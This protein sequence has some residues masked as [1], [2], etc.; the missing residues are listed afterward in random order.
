MQLH[1]RIEKTNVRGAPGVK[2]AK[3][4]QR[5]NVQDKNEKSDSKRTKDSP[6]AEGSIGRIG[7]F[8]FGSPPFGENPAGKA[9]GGRFLAT[10]I[11]LGA[12][13]Q[14]A[15]QLVIKVVH[16]NCRMSWP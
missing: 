15:F 11:T 2:P 12:R 6:S 9:K 1:G 4:F 16:G 3:R 14:E 10:A 8:A 13:P 7:A 5:L